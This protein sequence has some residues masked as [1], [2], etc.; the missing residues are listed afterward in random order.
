MAI[1]VE[2]DL[3]AP[4]SIASTP[5]CRGGHYSI[6]WIVPIYP[7]SLPYNTEL[8]KAASSTNFWVFGIIRPGIEPWS[9]RPLLNTRL[10]RLMAWFL[11]TH[12]HTHTYIYIYIY[13]YTRH[14]W[15]I[16]YCCRKW[17]QQSKFNPWMKL[18]AFHIGLIPL[19]KVLIQLFFL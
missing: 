14:S 8:S 4:F 17:T 6:P 19:G 18:F 2:G 1:V 11:H 12:T 13:I 10:F 7:W 3:K 5:R 9:P 15:C 16:V